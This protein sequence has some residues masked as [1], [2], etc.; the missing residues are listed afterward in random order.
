MGKNKTSYAKLL[1]TFT[2]IFSL[3]FASLSAIILSIEL[4]SITNEQENY[5]GQTLSLQLAKV[6]Q[7]SIINQDQLSLQIEIDDILTIE[8]VEHVAVHDAAKKLLAKATKSAN[9]TP[10]SSN[11]YTSTIT[12]ENATAGYVLVQFDQEFFAAYFQTLRLEIAFLFA[13]I[14]LVLIYLSA[15]IGKSLSSRLNHLIQQLPGDD[16]E[17]MDELSA[18]E[19]RLKPLIATRKENQQPYTEQGVEDYALLAIA[20][21][22]LT[23]LKTRVNPEH[24]ESVMS[25]FD[26][27]VNDATD[28]YGATRLSAGQ[29]SIYLKFKGKSEYGDHTL[30]ALYCATAIHAL[31]KKLLDTQ[32]IK[33]EIASAISNDIKKHSRSQ[34]LNESHC[35]VHLNSLQ[36]MLEQAVDGEILLDAPTKSH[37]SLQDISLCPPSEKSVLFRV[38][39]LDEGSKELISQQIAILSRDI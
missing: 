8:G 22:N 3:I 31:S 16:K 11:T 26:V 21:K 7:N 19:Y 6:A 28:I 24:L 10:L 38:E 15:K 34:I 14:F 23:I 27:L 5:L 25:Q 39:E 4:D 32:G 17:A 12:I 1:P 33:L 37:G 18:L 35:E 20:C 9:R 36:L 13:S 29:R 2:V 30:R